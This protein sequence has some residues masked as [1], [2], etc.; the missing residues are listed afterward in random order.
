MKFTV[1][2][3][4]ETRYEFTYYGGKMSDCEGWIF[5]G[6]KYIATMASVFLGGK[7]T[8]MS[9][10]LIVCPKLSMIWVGS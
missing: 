1:K 9:M 4:Q 2:K 5:D 6:C 10:L 3:D 8:V 7:Y